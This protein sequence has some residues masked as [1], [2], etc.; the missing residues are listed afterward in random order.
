LQQPGKALIVAIDALQAKQFLS[1]ELTAMA[2]EAE[3]KLLPPDHSHFDYFKRTKWIYVLNS[4]L[5]RDYLHLYLRPLLQKDITLVN[6]HGDPDLL[7][8]CDQDLAQIA[9]DI[10]YSTMALGEWPNLN[11]ERLDLDSN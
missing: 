3:V 4:K 6:K 5:Y 11:L 9:L 10:V 1:A 7:A 2:L 8:L